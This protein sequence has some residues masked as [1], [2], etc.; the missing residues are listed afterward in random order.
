MLKALVDSLDNLDDATKLLY[1]PV[2]EG[3]NAGKFIL[4]VEP[5]NGLTLENVDGLKSAFASTK[6]ELDSAK[7]AL[8]GYKGLPAPKTLRTQL[9]DL[10]RLKKIDPA[11]EAD[12][13]AAARVEAQVT[14]LTK[15]HTDEIG[16][17]DK[18][19]GQLS[20]EI[21]RLLVE[22]H[23]STAIIE[24][25]GVPE[26]LLGV[27]KPRLKVVETDGHFS[28]QVLDSNGNPDITIKDG[29][30]VNSTITDLVKKLKVD[31]KFGRAFEASGNS[32]SGA[33]GS[34]NGNLGSGTKANPWM[35]PTENLTEQMRITRADPT[36]AAAL[37]AQAGVA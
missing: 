33:S 35:K 17:R 25:K 19:E 13:L 34:G 23:A 3:D 30:P 11:S 15:S 21:T 2:T 6:G 27:I 8:E 16:K 28:V 7:A 32:G 36:L 5:V 20:G 1:V 31:P 22:S 12:R 37:K 10:E 18:R 26:L 14:E 24:E 9:A 4:A 29:K